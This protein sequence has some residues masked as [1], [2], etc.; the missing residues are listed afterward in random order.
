MT[1]TVFE[2][3]KTVH[4]RKGFDLW[5]VKITQRVPKSVF[6]E[7]L[8]HVK[9]VRGWYSGYSAEGS[10]PGFQFRTEETALDFIRIAKKIGKPIP[11]QRHTDSPYKKENPERL[12]PS[13][14]GTYSR[15]DK[16]IIN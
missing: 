15:T 3:V 10:I 6:L 13:L 1:N 2:T 8:E 5:V 9:S 4:A 14:S 7:W 11:Q 12:N 16:S